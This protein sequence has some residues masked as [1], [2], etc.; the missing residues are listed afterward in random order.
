MKS[1]WSKFYVWW[2]FFAPRQ[3]TVADYEMNVRRLCFDGILEIEEPSK[4]W[5]G[6]KVAR[7]NEKW[8]YEGIGERAQVAFNQSQI[9]FVMFDEWEIV[10]ATDHREC[11]RANEQK[12]NTSALLILRRRI[13][14]YVPKENNNKI[15]WQCSSYSY[16]AHRLCQRTARECRSWISDDKNW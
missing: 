5:H 15:R 9:E 10:I 2:W 1:V 13:S 7:A 12:Q 14:D 16:D 11:T 3:T 6:I 4:T 8:A